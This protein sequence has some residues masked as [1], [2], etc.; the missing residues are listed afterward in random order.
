MIGGVI[1]PE[2][3]VAKISRYG[4]NDESDIVGNLGLMFWRPSPLTFKDYYANKLEFRAE[5]YIAD[6]SK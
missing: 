4:I 1:V 5:D 3:R 2:Q 6:K